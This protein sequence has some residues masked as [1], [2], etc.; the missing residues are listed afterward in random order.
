MKRKARLNSRKAD[1]VGLQVAA[2]GR[3]IVA[4]VV[5]VKARLHL[6]PLTREAVIVRGGADNAVLLAEGQEDRVPDEA[7]VHIRHLLRRT[8]MIGMDEVHLLPVIGDKLHRVGK[9]RGQV[10][11]HLEPDRIGTHIPIEAV[12]REDNLVSLPRL[13]HELTERHPV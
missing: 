3:V 13:H 1:E 6:Q 12:T 7:P 8:Q 4:E 2:G 10:V 9:H 5:V 11:N